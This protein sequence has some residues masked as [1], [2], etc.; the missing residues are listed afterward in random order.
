MAPLQN[1]VLQIKSESFFF[2]RFWLVLVGIWSE[3]GRNLVSIFIT[4]RDHLV[5]F[6]WFWS[7]FGRNLVGH[8]FV[9]GELR[10]RQFFLKSVANSFFKIERSNDV[11]F[12]TSL[13][14]ETQIL[15]CL[16]WWWGRA[17]LEALLLSTPSDCRHFSSGSGT[18]TATFCLISVPLSVSLALCLYLCPFLCPSLFPSLSLSLSLSLSRAPYQSTLRPAYSGACARLN[19]D[20][21]RLAR[22]P[23]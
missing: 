18:S 23:R 9:P 8:V 7:E 20:S 13:A 5:G 6:G 4:D 16:R 22:R 10:P 15:K 11:M 2:G 12:G 21:N 17:G 1:F 3:F 19:S 14:P